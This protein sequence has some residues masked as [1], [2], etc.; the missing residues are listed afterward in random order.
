[1]SEETTRHLG[2]VGATSVGVGAI[3]GGG[4]LALAG[5]A[6]AT[7]GPAAILA[8]ALNGGIALLTAASFAELATRFPQSGG[9]Y[10]YAK[11]VLSIEAAFAVGWVVWFAS[12]VAGVLYALG[13]AAFA[14]EGVARLLEALGVSSGW[15]GRSPLRI[16]VAVA[17]TA[18]YGLLLARSA[19]GGGQ[20][21]TAGKLIVFAVLIA[22]GFW[23]VT[24]TPMS[25]LL[26]RLDPFFV[27]GSN[28]LIQAMGYTFIALQGFDLI[29]AV[30]GEVRDPERN[31]PRAMYLSLAIALAVYLP[32][33]FVLMTVGAPP[34]GIAEA[35]AA[36]PAGLVAE[37]AERF[38]GPAGYWL[39]IGAG[40]LSMLSALQANL[41]GAS[42]VAFAMARD[43]TLPRPLGRMRGS[44]GTPVLAVGVTA[45]LLA[46]LAIVVGDVSAAGAASSLIFLISFAMVHGAVILARRRSGGRAVPWIP[47]LGGVLCLALAVFQTFA[48]PEAGA[49][50]LTWLVI[51]AAF[52]FSWLARGAALADVASEARDPELARLRG[53]SPLVLVPIADPSSAAVLAGVA[54]T[55]RTPGVGRILLFSVVQELDEVP[56]EGHPALSNAQGILGEALRRSFERATPAETLFTVASDTVAEI[57]RVARLHRCETVL[58]GAPRF[59][60]AVIGP[61]VSELLLGLDADVVL[62]RAPH[63]WRVAQV[64]RVLVPIG[65]VRDHSRV[66]ARLLASL[67]RTD[68]CAVTF[69]RTVPPTASPEERLRADRELR[70]LARDEAGG[71][72]ELVIEE[73]ADPREAILRHAA[74]TDL[75]VMGLHRDRSTG[76]AIGDLSLTAG[77]PISNTGQGRRVSAGVEESSQGARGS[78]IRPAA[79]GCLAPTRGRAEAA[80]STENDLVRKHF[81]ALLA[82]GK[83]AGV[84]PDVLGRALLARLVELW[85]AERGWEDVASE[86]R[87]TA[88][89][90]DPDQDFEF[91]RP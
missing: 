7:S 2:L 84:P 68:T 74:D 11:R 90:L 83:S 52:Y 22:G 27:G 14:A 70:S 72:Y 13:F 28:G 6:F 16:T 62:V 29:A 51:G 25:T 3:V 88:D 53:R 76:R 10:T 49:I 61:R 34:N 42:R 79:G 36:N 32:L 40:V 1:V 12:I 50:V 38:L 33:L 9:T 4:I 75:V 20:T 77:C 85:L 56:A 78:G 5:T 26:G 73:A 80:V 71:Q 89:G 17:A 55:V 44:T 59:E 81:D 47:L 86:L 43:R 65:G 82:D 24:Q 31:L 48:V 15:L 69:L 45:A 67:S 63:R 60:G 37:A 39:V 8:F 19:R 35:A 87:F 57:L 91:M 46:A 54:A 64:R 23:A 18:C 66:R 41:L 30:G 21:A 58:M